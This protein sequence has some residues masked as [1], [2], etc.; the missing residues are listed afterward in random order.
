MAPTLTLNE[1]AMRLA[2]Y[3]AS[4]AATLRIAES[5]QAAA[6]GLYAHKMSSL[7]GFDVYIAESQQ[8]ETLSSATGKIALYGGI[9]DLKPADDWLAF[10]IAREMGH[11]LAG[12]H[13]QNSAASILTSVIMNLLIFTPFTAIQKSRWK[14]NPA[15]ST[16]A[17]LS[18]HLRMCTNGEN[19]IA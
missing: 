16:G 1:R 9:A 8:A 18:A 7:G 14:S 13:D 3:I 11:V 2:D 10:V 17:F 6:R 15:V 4:N 5:L 19:C 12:H